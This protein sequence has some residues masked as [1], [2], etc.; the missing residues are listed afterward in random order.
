M[1]KHVKVDNGPGTSPIPCSAAAE[2]MRTHRQRRKAGL[3]GVTIEL[4][5][6]EVTELIRRKLL[7]VGARHDLH[8]IRCALHRHL[9][10]SLSGSR[11]GPWCTRSNRRS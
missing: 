1:S 11:C 2:R 5:E 9:D 8:A 7:E 10:E 4:R 3:H 6:T